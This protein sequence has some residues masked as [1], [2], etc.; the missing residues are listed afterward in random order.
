MSQTRP[1]AWRG[2]PLG[3][4]LALVSLAQ[5]TACGGDDGPVTSPDP[6]MPGLDTTS[7][8][9][10][11]GPFVDDDS[12][13][14]DTALDTRPVDP[15]GD[16]GMRCEGNEDCDSGWCVDGPDG[17]ICT[18][19]CLERCPDGYGCRAVSAGGPDVS[20]ICVPSHTTYCAPCEADTD[21]T[22]LLAPTAG[23]R[24]LPAADGGGSFCGTLCASA[25][26]CPADGECAPASGDE[27]QR[28][29][30]PKTDETCGCSFWATATGAS[31]TCAVE[32]DA[33]RCTAGRG[34]SAD[35]L[36]ACVAATPTVERCN[37][38]D[39]DCDGDID[40][41]FSLLGTPCDSDDADLCE[42][43]SW[44]CGDDGAVVCAGD[45]EASVELCNGIDDD[46]DGETDESFPNEGVACDGPDVDECTD[47]V[48]VC[49]LDGLQCDDANNPR[50]EV[51]D[52]VDNDCNGATDAQ[53]EAL[54][55]AG[56]ALLDGVCAGAT[57]AADR[58]VNGS[59][60]PCTADDYTRTNAAYETASETR[61][62]TLDNDC[63]GSIDEDFAFTQLDGAVVQGAGVACGAGECSG[64]LTVCNVARDGILCTLEDDAIP[65]VCD[66]RDNDCDGVVD[67][68]DDSLVAVAC[69]LDA[70]VCSGVTRPANLCVD[71]TWEA[72][73]ALVYTLH[74]ARYEAGLETQ[75]DAA[76]NDCDGDI[77]EDFAVTLPDGAV[78]EGVNAACG[79]GACDGGVTRCTPEGDAT[80]CSTTVNVGAEL[81]DGT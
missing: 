9:Q 7:D 13:I 65:E 35:G 71:G 56:C 17:R 57:A 47:G 29:C 24:C 80:L 26:E 14:A 2:L 59:W 75:C 63:D 70:G 61:C 38:E 81:C 77:D 48:F 33:G 31:T 21:C 54:V 60:L 76:D 34:C 11:T 25:A 5:V 12:A 64:G 43:G 45:V 27:T 1:R 23:H 69:A 20:F 28:Y 53:D 3:I 51:C 6:F 67:A 50:P 62:D 40:E 36:D 10:V 4:L 44:A 42:L 74:D 37:G 39:D 66:G 55:L 18:V 30:Q 46:C 78:V 79:V 73:T 15:G 32:N 68:A 41:D 16:F 49:T 58:C 52:G 22:S 72:C 8:G 19:T